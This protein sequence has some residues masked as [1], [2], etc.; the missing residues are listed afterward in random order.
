MEDGLYSRA[1]YDQGN[2]VLYS[3]KMRGE[4]RNKIVFGKT[5]W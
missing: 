3:L 5:T 2:V 1:G 4:M